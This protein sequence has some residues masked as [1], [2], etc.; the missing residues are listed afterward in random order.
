MQL[1]CQLFILQNLYNAWHT[2]FIQYYSVIQSSILP[3]IP[4]LCIN[5]QLNHTKSHHCM[6]SQSMYQH[7]TQS[8]KVPSLYVFPV[9][10]STYYSVIQSPI[11]VCIPSLCINILLS[12]T[13]SHPCMYSQFMYQHTT[14]SYKVPS[15][16]VFPVYVLTYSAYI[17]FNP[18][19]TDVYPF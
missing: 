15:L 18:F 7:T 4:S 12:H 9:Y 5:I 2:V 6:Y 3:C 17:P 8:Y 14:Q 11:L 19:I 10:V 1:W 13:K 16:Y